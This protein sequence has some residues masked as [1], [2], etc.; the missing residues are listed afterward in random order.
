MRN[1]DPVKHPEEEDC[2]VFTYS[3]VYHYYKYIHQFE[4]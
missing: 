3:S 4:L 2:M 1:I